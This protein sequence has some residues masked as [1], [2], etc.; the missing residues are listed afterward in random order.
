MFDKV[1]FICD[2]FPFYRFFGAC[3][4]QIEAYLFPTVLCINGQ[5]LAAN[6]LV[7]SGGM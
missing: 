5:E 6:A 1:V 2:F 3:L 4:R 7:N